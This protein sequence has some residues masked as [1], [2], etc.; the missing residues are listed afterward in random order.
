MKGLEYGRAYQY[1]HD[2]PGNWVAQDY[3]PKEL[4]GEQYYFPAESGA[5]KE[6]QKRL[7]K[8]GMKKNE[9]GKKT[10]KGV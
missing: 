8:R 3:L 1:P 7:D 9:N 5:E 4:V 2:F 10:E 6:V